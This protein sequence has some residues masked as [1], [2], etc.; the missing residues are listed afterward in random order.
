MK[1]HGIQLEE[2]SAVTNMTV[3]SGTAFPSSPNE[4]ELF[5]RSDADR[6]VK[7]MYAYIAGSWD[8]IASSDSVTVPAGTSLP[9]SA[10]PGDLYYLDTNDSSESLYVYIAGAWTRVTTQHDMVV[11]SGTTFP[12]SPT[13]GQLFFK[14]SNDVNEGLYYYDADTTSWMAAGNGSGG[15][16]TPGGS[17]TQVQFNS[18][19]SFAG[20]SSLT[21]NAGTSTLSASNFSGNGSALTALNASNLSSGTVGTA[22]LGSG[23]ASS[24]TYLRGDGTWSTVTSGGTPGGSTTQVQ[25]NSSGS[26]AGS[27]GLTWDGTVLTA[28]SITSSG[29]LTVGAGALITPTSGGGSV[30][31]G[32][33]ASGSHLMGGNT[34]HNFHIDASDDNGTT[35]GTLYLNWFK[36][37]SV[38]FG[39]GATGASGA[40]V[41]NTGVITAGGTGFSGPG[42][43]IS[44]L[45]ASNLTTGTVPTARLGSGTANS[46]TYLRGDGTWAAAPTGVPRSTTTGTATAGDAGKCIAVT[47]GITIPA[48]TFSAGDSVS[49]YNNSGATVTITQGSGL[50]MHL[51]GTASTGNRTLLQRGMA[52]IWFNSATDCVITGGGVQ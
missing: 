5:Y 2:G 30:R 32:N 11:P 29:L 37:S 18:S 22:R 40:S 41:S 31:I 7:G 50:T 21:W 51:V 4:G 28:S 38:V 49:I 43:N 25:F 17:D 1:F 42:V 24:S 36:G 16:G 34:F 47:A 8:R 12:S 13:A 3:A 35:A 27:A 10:N 6:T 52:T 9:S 23:T 15:G 33:S 14:N 39:N 48:S 46:T 19:G 45:N 26:F 44:T 20:S